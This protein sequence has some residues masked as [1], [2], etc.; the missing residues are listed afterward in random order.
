[1]KR[2]KV[3]RR[4]RLPDDDPDPDDPTRH[5]DPDPV[6]DLARALAANR[7]WDRRLL[8]ARIHDHWEEIAGASLAPHVRPLRLHGGVLVVSVSSA[9][10]ATQ[11][12]YLST[13]LMER[14]NQVLGQGAV[15]SIKVTT[16]DPADRRRRR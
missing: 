14:A 8:G 16:D 4:K 7:G 11:L 5:R 1:M 13:E 3:N 15:T 6:G 10:W 2:G 12:R 9:A